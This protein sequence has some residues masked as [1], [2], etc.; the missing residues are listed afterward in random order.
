MPRGDG[1]GPQGQGSKTG[2]GQGRCD[3]KGTP[4]AP[5]DRRGKGTGKYKPLT[6]H[7]YYPPDGL[8]GALGFLNV[9]KDRLERL[10][11]EGFNNTVNHNCEANGCILP[12]KLSFSEEKAA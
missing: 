4:S 6:I 12:D 5:R 3:P 7:R 9:H 11:D 8:D 10:I 2:R 1:T